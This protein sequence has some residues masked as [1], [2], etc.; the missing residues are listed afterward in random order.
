VT[1]AVVVASPDSSPEVHEVTLRDLGPQDVRVRIAAAGVCHSDLSMANGTLGPSFPVVIGHE[2]A[3][4]VVEVGASVTDA[5]VGERVVLN[6]APACRTCWF[7]RRNEPWLCQIAS[8]IAS[9]P[10]GHLYNGREV[11]GAM[12][13]GAFAE[14]I[15]ISADAILPLPSEVP[16]DIGALLGCAVLTGF[17]AA[18]RAAQVGPGDAVLVL[19]LGGVGLSTVVGA[20]IAGAGLIIGADLNPQKEELARML[21]ATNF[22]QSGPDLAKQVRALTGRRGVD[23]AFECVGRAETIRQGWSATRRGGRCTVVGVGG[24]DQVVTFSAM[25]LFHS[26]RTL[27]SSIY[28]STDPRRDIESL[29]TLIATGRMNLR[30]LVSDKIGLHDVGAAFERMQRGEGARSIIYFDQSNDPAPDS[31]EGTS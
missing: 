2:A 8:G 28:G 1:K 5:V 12:G 25:E 19:G 9:T 14:E 27:T 26:A 24:Q 18:N 21:G 6:W 17:G 16:F 23:H 15:V 11:H 3:G 20:R 30:P 22:V 4:T 7:C 29:S 10:F 13:V 31:Q